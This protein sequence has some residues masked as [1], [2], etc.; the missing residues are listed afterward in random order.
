LALVGRVQDVFDATNQSPVFE[1]N[2]RPSGEPWV[3]RGPTWG[4]DLHNS[5]EGYTA[6]LQQIIKV[7]NHTVVVGGRYL[8]F[9]SETRSLLVRPGGL[10]ALFYTNNI[11]QEV[12]GKV[13]RASAYVYDFWQPFDRL[14]LTAGVA[15]DHLSFPENHEI[16]PL[17][18]D[19]SDR[20]QLSPK[21]GFL[22]KPL[23]DLFVRGAYTRSL[24]GV[25]FDNSIQLEPTTVAG[26]NQRYRSVIPESIAGN[27]PGARFETFGLGAEQKFSS[28][29]YI[30]LAGEILDS[31]GTRA[32]GGTTRTN[33]VLVGRLG[34]P[35]NFSDR[36]EYQERTL[37]F[38]VNQLVGENLA[39]GVR[40]RLTD[41]EIHSHIP[42]VPNHLLDSDLE[43]TLHQVHLYMLL[44]WQSGFFSQLE[45]IWSGQDSRG[46]TPMVEDES[47]WQLNAFAGYRFWR[48]HAE[49]RVG[50]LNITDRNYQLN[51]L[52]LY[53]ELPRERTFYASFKFY[54]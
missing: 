16:P 24:G 1:L 23:D 44:N 28:G 13:E 34:R 15:Y 9:D 52:T 27:V 5:L 22:W 3:I 45:A 6:E 30:S 48:R 46:Y 33:G 49:A 50:V 47:F 38:A 25:F 10:F 51:P 20:S 53:S 36:L 4:K 29:T 18:R 26:F 14:Q 8:S 7:D 17:S 21:A 32:F 12:D 39:F 37:T 43:S 35:V 2:R 11:F 40:Y 19:E 54:F 31:T 41:S 42:G